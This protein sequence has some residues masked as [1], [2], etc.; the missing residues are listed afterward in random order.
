VARGNLE[1][2]SSLGDLR[3]VVWHKIGYITILKFKGGLHGGDTSIYNPTKPRCV[4]RKGEAKPEFY[5][6]ENK[7]KFSPL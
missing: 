7:A 1:G 2:C 4:S 6:L 3:C 5:S